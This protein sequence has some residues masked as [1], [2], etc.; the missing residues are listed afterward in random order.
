MGPL[1][2]LAELWAS[3]MGDLMHAATRIEVVDV[4]AV[5]DHAIDATLVTAVKSAAKAGT[6][7]HL[8][9][10][11][12]PAPRPGDRLLVICDSECPRAIGIEHAGA[13]QVVAQ[14]PGDGAFVTPN[15]VETSS[16]ALLAAGQPAPDLCIRGIVELLDEV[17]R[18]GFEV[19]VRAT[20]GNGAGTIASHKVKAS[21]SVVW[22]ASES[23][24]LEVRLSGKGTVELVADHAGRDKD[25]CYS[26]QFL[27]S[28]PLARTAKSLDRALDGAAGPAVIARGTLTVPKGGPVPAGAH[29][30]EFS[31]SNDGYLELASDLAEGRVSLTSNERGHYR[32][33]FPTKGGAPNDPELDFDFATDI[34][35]GYE[36]GA[37]LAKALHAT[38]TAQLTW[39]Q[40]SKRTSLGAL[41]LTYVREPTSAAKPTVP[42]KPRK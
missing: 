31:A 4:T 15:V 29:K 27:P 8:D 13:F 10:G 2:L 22:F 38:S 36:H 18:P 23:G 42:T 34:L 24:A 17:A 33:G 1:I 32:L 11:Y 14:E 28:R 6:K 26:A 39:V 41:A 30:I 35:P 40:G 37:G 21:L 3:S 20:D 7:V 19:H 12:L 25:G 9:L 5:K 16:L